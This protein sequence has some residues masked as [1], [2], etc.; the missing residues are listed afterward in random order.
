LGRAF[1][2]DMENKGWLKRSPTTRAIILS[3]PGA[4]A[5]DQAFPPI[6]AAVRLDAAPDSP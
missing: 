6:I 2:A 5:F 1:L 4:V 3:A